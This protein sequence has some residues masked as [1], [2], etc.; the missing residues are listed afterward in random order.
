M[1]SLIDEI[2][3]IS[4][5]QKK[6]KHRIGCSCASCRRKWKRM[7]NANRH[8]SAVRPAVKIKTGDFSAD[9]LKVQRREHEAEEIRFSFS[10]IPKTVIRF[11]RRG[12]ERLAIRKAISLGITNEN[13]LS[14]MIFFKRHPERRGKLIHRREKNFKALSKEWL[15]IR[16]NMVRPILT[17]RP[18]PV[19][20]DDFIGRRVNI[21]GNV[22]APCGIRL[23]QKPIPGSKFGKVYPKFDPV[24]IFAFSNVSSPGWIKIRTKDQS[25]GWIEERFIDLRNSGTHRFH[26][27]I[28]QMDKG[29]E[30]LAH[31]LVYNPKRVNNA[32]TKELLRRFGYN[33]DSMIVKRGSRGF[34]CILIRPIQC[35]HPGPFVPVIAFKGTD[36]LNDLIT[37]MDFSSPGRAQFH[38]NR[39]LIENLLNRVEGKVDLTGHSLGGATAQRATVAF[40]SKVRRLVTFQSPAIEQHAAQS[41]KRNADVVHHLALQDFVD[42]SGERHIRGKFFVHHLLNISKIDK[43]AIVPHR[44]VLTSS[45]KVW[46]RPS[47]RNLNRLSRFK[48]A[49]LLRVR[50]VRHRVVLHRHFPFFGAKRAA[51]ETARSILSLNTAV[52]RAVT[53]WLSDLQDFLSKEVIY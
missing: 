2:L 45:A 3:E 27:Q 19:K 36:S 33:P 8:F 26:P 32:N 52:P 22:F 35:S 42:L 51:L 37:D 9:A 39:E 16:N 17:S 49:K 21:K 12:L 47:E 29:L 4:P 6:K 11:L 34:L 53:A 40:P 30:F 7:R 46:D 41:F 38:H 23:H 10:G 28:N 48:G 50:P 1:E 18:A 44:T 25:E 43:A 24:R 5:S 31:F 13:V 20:K 15:K 14:D